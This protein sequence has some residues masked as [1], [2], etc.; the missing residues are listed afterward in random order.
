MLVHAP[1]RLGQRRVAARVAPY[2]GRELEMHGAQLARQAQRLQR[3]RV[4]PPEFVAQLAG[5][6]VVVEERRRPTVEPA[7]MSAG[8]ADSGVWWL[9]NSRNAL[10]LKTKPSGV[11][12]SQRQAFSAVGSA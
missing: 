1:R 8:R 12:W 3:Q 7:R 6:V 5:H 9:V 10:M 2:P 11:R 4:A